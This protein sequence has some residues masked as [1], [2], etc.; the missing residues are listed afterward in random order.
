ME[1]G[2]R[3]SERALSALQ[4]GKDEFEP[5]LVAKEEDRRAETS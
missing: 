4:E 5:F 1:E 3:H 2:I